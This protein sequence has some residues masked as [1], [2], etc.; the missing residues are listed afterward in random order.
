MS[1]RPILL[2]SICLLST[3]S[4]R[5]QQDI[6]DLK[7]GDP[8]RQY[9][10]E[11]P[12]DA[13]VD[14]LRDD[15]I[16]AQTLRERLTGQRIVLIGEQHTDAAYHGVQ[17][18]ALELLRRAGTPLLI[19]L[20]MFPADRQSVLDAWS[21]GELDESDFLTSAD[22]YHIWGYDWRYYREIFHFARANSIPMIGLNAP[23]PGGPDSTIA[24][25]L[26]SDDHETLL[27]A[28]FESDSPVHGGLSDEQFEA[29]FAAQSRRDA[30]M[31][32]HLMDALRRYPR[33]TAVVLAGTGHV[34][35]ELGIVRQLP[36][37]ERAVAATILP[38]PVP[39]DVD[40]ATVTA[41]VAD[42][43]WGVPASVFPAYPELG[44]LTTT[45]AAGLH[46]I[47]VEPESPAASAGIETG[48]ALTRYRNVALAERTDLARALASA[49]WGD[50][51]VI[52]LTRGAEARQVT[53]ALRR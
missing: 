15:V 7:I 31:A 42:F 5:G 24:A 26:E 50:E 1:A 25:D 45:T 16:S 44:V 11:V 18:R 35:Y 38:V 27:R 6:A 2:M 37:T 12:R 20:E 19:G 47:Y 33:R 14:T 39:S 43:A 49:R 36:A 41:S 51:A 34:L 17:L 29:L 8:Q 9:P 46:V 4:A 13:I 48:D 28:F 32:L 40:T 23:Q 52:S 22:W 10:I 30:T 53:I 21:R 3:G